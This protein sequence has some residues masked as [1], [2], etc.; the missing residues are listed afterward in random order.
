[1]TLPLHLP[2]PARRMR[3]ALVTV[4]VLALGAC[5]GGDGRAAEAA[6]RSG[7]AASTPGDSTRLRAIA[8]T[9]RIQGRPGAKLWMIVVSDF[10]CPFCR[11]WHQE[12]YDALRREYVETGKVRMAYVH[13]PLEQHRQ[14]TP[15]AE[16]SMCAGAQGRFWPYEAALFEAA[17]AWGRGGRAPAVFDS[18][19]GVVGVDRTAFRRCMDSDVMLAVV[20]ADRDRALQAGVR[21]T[22]AFIIGRTI[23]SGAQPVVAFRQVIDAALAQQGA[24]R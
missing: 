13:F 2:R 14:A 1:M 16:A 24:G 7:V 10:Q 23:V 5:T 20:E 18:L 17:D 9:A 22:P 21:S 3:A 4:A 8:D 12:T 19:A 11:V 15:A 6:E